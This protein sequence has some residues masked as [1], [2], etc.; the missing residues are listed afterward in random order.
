MFESHRAHFRFLPV[1][2]NSVKKTLFSG[3]VVGVIV[4]TV[5]LAAISL[6]M[7]LG[8]ANNPLAYIGFIATV[9]LAVL[10]M[11][12]LISRSSWGVPQID[13]SLAEDAKSVV[14]TNTGNGVAKNLRVSLVPLDQEVSI[15]SL[16]PDASHRI[17]FPS[18]VSQV[19]VVVIF[20]NEEGVRLEKSFLF[21]ALGR[22]GGGEEDIFKP[23]IPLFEWKK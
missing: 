9:I 17:S 16:D 7:Y 23:V 4:V 22:H 11:S 20:E 3:T 18:M 5:V 6:V 19:K 13:A 12:I 2:G 15:E 1:W 21:S 14:I 10:A 8:D